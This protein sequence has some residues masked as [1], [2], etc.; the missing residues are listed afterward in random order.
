MKLD[1]VLERLDSFKDVFLKNELEKAKLQ[2]KL[3]IG[4]KIEDVEGEFLKKLSNTKKLCE[5]AILKMKSSYTEEISN[6]K[7]LIKVRK[8]LIIKL[9]LNLFQIY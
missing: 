9:K 2:L 5:K 4:T 6:L 7:Q 1:N 8:V 3:E